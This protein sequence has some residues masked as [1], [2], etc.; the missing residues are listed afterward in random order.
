M[1]LNL[2]MMKLVELLEYPHIYKLPP[3]PY[4]YDA[5][6][7]HIDAETMKEHYIKHQKGYVDKLNSEFEDYPHLRK[8]LDDIL[9]NINS[10]NSNIR[11]NAGGV[12]NHTFFWNLLSPTKTLP[13]GRLKLH[14]LRQWQSVDLF[15]KDFIEAGKMHFGSGWVWLVFNSKK[16]SLEI[17]STPNQD[18]PMMLHSELKPIIGCDLW[19]HAYYLKH[20]SNKEAWL[21]AFFEILN[22]DYSLSLYETYT[23]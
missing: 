21:N 5:L 17:I 8:P 14:I 23:K 4:D 12:W 9:K 18:N 16:N 19:E 1:K 10:Y 3:L 20:K 7:P 11:N 6:E 22:W 15:I 2:K 13:H